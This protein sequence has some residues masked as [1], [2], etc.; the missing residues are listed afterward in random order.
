[1]KRTFSPKAEE[2]DRHWFVVDA[3]G[4]TVGRLSTTI[5]HLITGKHKPRYAPHVDCGDFVI[6]VNAEKSVLTGRKE[7][8]KYYYRASTQ[9]GGLKA[10]VAADVR[11]QSPIRLIESSVY[12]ML[13][14]NRLGRKL[15]HKLKVYAGPNHPHQA[16]KPQSL[17][18][19]AS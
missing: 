2:I 19:A 4:Q 18:L 15:R 12:G 10:V 11:R 17:A 6:V 7:G 13:P 1:M 8:Q 3:A 16:Q 14:K 5:A 9:P